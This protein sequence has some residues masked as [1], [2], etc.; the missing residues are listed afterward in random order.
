MCV[1]DYD[2]DDDG[3]NDEH[4]GEEHVFPDERDSAGG[5]GDQ[6]HNNQQENGQRQQDRDGEGHLFTWRTQRT[7]SMHMITK[8]GHDGGPRLFSHT[9]EATGFE[10]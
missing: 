9:D 7:N 5:G 1:D 3:S 8:S 6:L 10:M 4:H 2:R